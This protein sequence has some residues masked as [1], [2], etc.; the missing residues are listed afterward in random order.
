MLASRRESKF[1]P[2]DGSDP[3]EPSAFR[4]CLMLRRLL[5]A[6]FIVLLLLKEKKKTRDCLI[7]NTDTEKWGAHSFLDGDRKHRNADN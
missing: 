7:M 1:S 6:T 5:L 3:T 2:A 4:C